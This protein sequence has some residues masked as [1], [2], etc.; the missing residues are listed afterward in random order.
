MK[1]IK[2]HCLFEPIHGFYPSENICEG[3]PDCIGCGYL[4][5]EKEEEK[6]E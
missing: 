6:E 5:I 4:Y 2:K 3:H 1:E